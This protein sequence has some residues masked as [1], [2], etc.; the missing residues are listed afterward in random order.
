MAHAL[1][2]NEVQVHVVDLLAAIGAGVHD[3]AVAGFGD[4]L[5]LG[6][7]AHQAEHAPGEGFVFG[8]E[9]IVVGDVLV[10][11]DENVGGG[12][13]ID[14]AEG[15]DGLVGIYGIAGNLPGDDLAEDAVA[16]H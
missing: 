15:G 11:D 16:N 3:E 4:A 2:A 12:G 13:G 6:E 1:A 9:G 10:R 7:G 8:L 14:V 5:L